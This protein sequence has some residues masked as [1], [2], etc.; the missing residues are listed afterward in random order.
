M[1]R[2]EVCPVGGF[3][4]PW[5]FGVF[6]TYFGT[7]TFTVWITAILPDTFY[8]FDKRRNQAVYRGTGVRAPKKRC[9]FDAGTVAVFVPL[10]I[11]QWRTSHKRKFE[12][13]LY[14]W[15]NKYVFLVR[16]ADTWS[17]SFITKKLS[18]RRRKKKKIREPQKT[19]WGINIY[20]PRNPL[21]CAINNTPGRRPKSIPANVHAGRSIQ[22]GENLH[23]SY[24]PSQR[25]H[26]S[27]WGGGGLLLCPIFR[28]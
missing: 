16:H 9:W 26:L 6:V 15:S 7:K 10:Y 14:F 12:G 22:T 24:V 18:Q 25:P 28:Q 23:V 2:G 8:S 11:V 27:G 4:I 3:D 20:T 5:K 1:R 19:T 13:S 21:V 17:L